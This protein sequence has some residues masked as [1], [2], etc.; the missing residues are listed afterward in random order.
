MQ[1]EKKKHMVSLVVFSIMRLLV[2]VVLIRQIM[3]HNYESAFLCVLTMLLLYVPCWIQLKIKIEL[4]QPLE[5]TILCFIFAAEVLGE[6][7][8][9]YVRIPGWDTVLHMINGFLMA[10]V[11][12]SLT[13]LLNQHKREVFALS[14]LFLS[15][16]AFCFSMTIGVMWEFFEFG[17]DACFHMDMQKDTVIHGI[18]SV[19]LDITASN[20]VVAL[21]DI[22]DV[23]INGVSLGV[24]GYLDI[25]L[26]DTMKDLLVNF[27]GATVFSVIGFLCISDKAPL[28]FIME[29]FVPRERGEEILKVRKNEQNE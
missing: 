22:R 19:A 2:A 11:G 1:P 23:T 14:P 26:I 5:I 28:R 12:F 13:M 25:G 4:P 20:Q 9:F 29:A 15:I 3:L 6:I 16:T 24:N 17:M 21:E 27:I 18:Y 10:A 7:N 8:A